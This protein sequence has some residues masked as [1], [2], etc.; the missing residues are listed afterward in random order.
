[1]KRIV[2]LKAWLQVEK[3]IRHEDLLDVP[4]SDGSEPFIFSIGEQ[5]LQATNR[6]R[7]TWKQIYLEADPE[8]PLQMLQE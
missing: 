6:K 4:D 5:H 7:A 1:M 8:A 3:T 2:T